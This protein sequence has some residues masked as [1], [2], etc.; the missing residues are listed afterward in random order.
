[1]KTII[2]SFL[3][4][5]KNIKK[6]SN[7]T[8]VSY[9]ND[10]DSLAVYLQSQYEIS[11]IEHVNHLMIRSWIMELK[12]EGLSNTSINRKISAVKTFYKYVRRKGL[13]VK[14]PM[15][16]IQTLKK[17]KRLPSYVPKSKMVHLQ[18]EYIGSKSFVSARDE[19][20][21]MLLYFTGMRRSELINLQDTDIHASRLEIKVIGKGNKERLCPITSEVVAKVDAYVDLRNEEFGELDHTF[22]IVTEKGKPCY[23]KLIYNIVSRE[24]KKINASE[25]TSPHV[26]RHTFAT[27]LSSNGAELNAVKELLGHAS[28]AA[29]QVYTHNTIDRLKKEYKKAH[30]K[31]E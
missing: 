29:T 31:G 15:V 3:L 23:P 10:L 26:L 30:P 8:I 4:Y 12:S 27:H 11:S 2:D 21:I 22:L 5:L 14:N 17:S 13:V 28:L 20:I 19:L 1:M 25:K 18:E 9:E 24:L 6:N 16:K 7:H